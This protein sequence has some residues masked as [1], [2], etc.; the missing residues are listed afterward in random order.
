MLKI[1]FLWIVVQLFMKD[2][3]KLWC[4]NMLR[5]RRRTKRRKVLKFTN[6]FYR[7]GLSRH[8][9][10]AIGRLVTGPLSMTMLTTSRVMWLPASGSGENTC[11]Q[12]CH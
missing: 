9:L 4:T 11:A 7:T 3:D 2:S 1:G 8:L 5:T 12:T 10:R 6:M